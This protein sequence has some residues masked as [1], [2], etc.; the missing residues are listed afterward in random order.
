[1]IMGVKLFEFKDFIKRLRGK[2]KAI[3][4]DLPEKGRPQLLNTTIKWYT[5]KE[6]I[7]SREEK[8]VNGYPFFFKGY[9]RKNRDIFPK[10]DTT[11]YL[12]ENI[13]F[14]RRYNDIPGTHYYEFIISEHTIR[15]YWFR[16]EKK[17]WGYYKIRD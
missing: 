7:I 4:P 10:K 12:V 11:S 8:Y 5:L 1:M 16:K 6:G 9:N 3:I 2:D 14:T 17:H 15:K 13:D